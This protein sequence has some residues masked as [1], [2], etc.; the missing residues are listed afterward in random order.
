MTILDFHTSIREL[1]NIGQG[2]YYPP[3]TIDIHINTSLK[4]LYRQEYQHFE[5]TQQITDTL[6]FYKKTSGLIVLVNGEGD[7]PTDYYH[8]T[9]AESLDSQD[10][11][12][13]CEV[14]KDAHWTNRKHS[15]GFAPSTEYPIARQSGSAKIEA[16]PSS[17]AKLRIF[18]LRRPATAKYAY[19]VSASGTGFV[20]DEGNSVQIDWPEIDHPRIQLKVLGL[21]GLSLR[22]PDLMRNENIAK[23]QNENA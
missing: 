10:N 21:L 6:G 11:A 17:I 14:L 4:D 1:V 3:E 12:R 23:S 7:L 22:D 9:G 13:P 8:I 20:Y 19:T 18:Y 2:Q 16:L 5:A 15:A